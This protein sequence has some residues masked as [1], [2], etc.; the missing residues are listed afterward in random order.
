MEDKNKQKTSKKYD[1]NFCCGKCHYV[2]S[3]KYNYD[4][5]CS[6]AKHKKAIN[7]DNGGQNQAKLSKYIDIEQRFI[8]S[9]GKEYKCRQGLWKHKK[10]CN[11][12]KVNPPIK[13]E[14]TNDDK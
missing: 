2:T 9:C 4:V 14:K 7:E 11:N 12:S 8:C 1:L 3:K 10:N 5:H 13:S 6:T